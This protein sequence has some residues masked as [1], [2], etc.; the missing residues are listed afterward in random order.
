M[1]HNMKTFTNIKSNG[2]HFAGA[3]PDT[4]E[5][6]LAVLK[7]E[8]LDRTFENYGNFVYALGGRHGYEDPE[9]RR[10]AKELRAV[11]FFGNFFK[12]SHVFNIE[13]NDPAVIRPL[14]K[15]IRANQRRA[16]YLSQHLPKLKKAA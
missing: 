9:L 6:L 3:G 11:N 5:Q 12:L 4:I 1:S 10:E 13:T 16:D 7:D 14:V 2:S 8:P 15:A